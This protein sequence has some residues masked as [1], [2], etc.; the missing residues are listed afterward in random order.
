MLKLYIIDATKEWLS[1]AAVLFYGNK[2]PFTNLDVVLKTTTFNI[3][4]SGITTESS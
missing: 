3:N 2:S 4:F 1:G